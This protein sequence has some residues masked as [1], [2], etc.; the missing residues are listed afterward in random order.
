MSFGDLTWE[1]TLPSYLT[2]TDKTRLKDGLSQFFNPEH[3]QKDKRYDNFYLNKPPAFF[4]Q[5]DLINSLHVYDWSFENDVYTTGFSPV[6]II[7]SS[8]DV[9][10]KEEKL[11]EKEALFARLIPLE[12]FFSDLKD[13][14]YTKENIASIYN[15][16]KNQAYTNLFYLPPNPIDSRE[17]IVFFDKIFWHPSE[18]FFEKLKNINDARFLSLDHF[19][20]YLFI[21]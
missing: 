15:G 6:I 8:C 16:L 3:R 12:D 1:A 10:P 4:M 17:F 21:H 7:S 5:G 18:N 13:D 19:G 2:I 9:F 20:F 11:L 14:G